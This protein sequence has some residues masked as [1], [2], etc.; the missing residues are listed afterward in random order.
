MIYVTFR[1]LIENNQ[2]LILPVDKTR[3]ERL[4][5]GID[6]LSHVSAPSAMNVTLHI[7]VLLRHLNFLF[8]VNFVSETSLRVAAKLLHAL[9]SQRKL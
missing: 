9:K 5:A 7:A 1:Q 3:H 6:R 8:L 2:R 4:H